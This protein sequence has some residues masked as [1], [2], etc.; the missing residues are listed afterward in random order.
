MVSILDHSP[1]HGITEEVAPSDLTV[2]T[3]AVSAEELMVVVVEVVTTETTLL[4][5]CTS[6]LGCPCV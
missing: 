3:V 6:I 5:C 2:L 1:G 4:L